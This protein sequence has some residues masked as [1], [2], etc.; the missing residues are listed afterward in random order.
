MNSKIDKMIA[1]NCLKIAY[2]NGKNTAPIRLLD[3][4]SLPKPL[5]RARK[6]KTNGYRQTRG[7]RITFLVNKVS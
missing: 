4:K 3:A 1:Q 7:F 6:Y 5:E 2:E